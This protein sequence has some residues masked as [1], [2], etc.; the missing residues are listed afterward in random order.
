MTLLLPEQYNILW[1]TSW[2]SLISTAEAIRQEEYDVAICVGSVLLT[3][4]NYW[5][6]PIL[7]S[8]GEKIDEIVVRITYSYMVYKSIIMGR[9]I[10]LLISGLGVLSSYI[11]LYFYYQHKYWTYTYFH[12]GLHILANIANFYLL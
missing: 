9:Y 2:I 7:H 6:K 1:G 10:Y 11:G 3:S 5:R 12:M 8:Y 4:L